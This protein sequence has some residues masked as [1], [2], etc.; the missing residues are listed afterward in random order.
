MP[1][2]TWEPDRQRTLCGRSSSARFARSAGG[3]FPRLGS[4]AQSWGREGNQRGRR[5]VVSVALG[6][7]NL[8]KGLV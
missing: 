1:R 5:L 4:R 6:S 8:P 7:G 2:D 3:T